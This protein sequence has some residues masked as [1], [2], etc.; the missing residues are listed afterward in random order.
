MPGFLHP[1]PSHHAGHVQDSCELSVQ[2]PLAH[3]WEWSRWAGKPSQDSLL[4]DGLGAAPWQEGVWAGRQARPSHLW[5][6]G[7]TR[8]H[9]STEVRPELCPWGFAEVAGWLGGRGGLILHSLALLRE[10][11]GHLPPKAG[12][13]WSW[14]V[15]SWK[16]PKQDP[17]LSPHTYP[18]ISQPC[19]LERRGLGLFTAISLAPIND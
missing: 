6:P 1:T 4:K 2:K 17:L 7:V 8:M 12:S 5:C 15:C 10:N 16:G 3:G 11:V 14:W 9:K 13:L 19:L 18:T